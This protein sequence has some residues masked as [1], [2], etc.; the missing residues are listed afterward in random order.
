MGFAQGTQMIVRTL[1]NLIGGVALGI[2]DINTFALVNALT[3]LIVFFVTFVIRKDLVKNEPKI[4]DNTKISLGN[5]MSHLVDSIKYLFNIHKI[6]KFL[7]VFALSQ[8]ILNLIIPV[9][10]IILISFPF[11]G[12]E[13]GLSI[14]I[15]TTIIFIGMIV[16]NIAS[17]TLFKKLTTKL[18]TI[19][20]QLM[21]IIILLV[22]LSIILGL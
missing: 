3:F 8:S 17:G 16:G 2:I 7:M 5:C 9:S 19:L 22:L 14:S 18:V 10:A 1:S 20:S 6:G 13:A 15:L 11:M 12:F 4:D 21:Q